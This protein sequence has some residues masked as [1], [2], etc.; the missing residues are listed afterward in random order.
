MTN[1]IQFPAAT[2]QKLNPQEEEALRLIESL[3]QTLATLTDV[4][5]AI[6]ISG[7][8]EQVKFDVLGHVLEAGQHLQSV[9]EKVVKDLC[10]VPLSGT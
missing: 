1:V 9:S 8:S 6:K 10:L 4:S 7:L 3:Q 2:K 5:G